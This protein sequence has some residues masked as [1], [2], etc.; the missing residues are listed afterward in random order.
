MRSALPTP[1]SATTALRLRSEL[2]C[3]CVQRW[4]KLLKDSSGVWWRVETDIACPA[5]IG[6][7]S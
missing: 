6:V 7:E 3:A 1:A 4:C 2:D 5:G